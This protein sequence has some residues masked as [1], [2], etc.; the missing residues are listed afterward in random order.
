MLS[1]RIQGGQG[2]TSLRQGGIHPAEGWEGWSDQCMQSY[3]SSPLLGQT[4]RGRPTDVCEGGII[5]GSF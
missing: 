5:D 1:Q 3:E 4:T 2:T